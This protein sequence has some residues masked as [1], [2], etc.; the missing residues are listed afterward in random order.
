MMPPGGGGSGG[1]GSG[2]GSIIVQNPLHGLNV[3]SAWTAYK[4]NNAMGRMGNVGVNNAVNVIDM[5]VSKG[6]ASPIV[7]INSQIML[8]VGNMPQMPRMKQ[9]SSPLVNRKSPQNRQFAI[10]MKPTRTSSKQT[11]EPSFN[12]DFGI[13][14]TKRKKTG[15]VF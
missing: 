8:N 4:V 12:I 15:M 9:Q 1:R 5:K 11:P 10:N 14:G 6:R 13:F 2:H 7:K 3:A